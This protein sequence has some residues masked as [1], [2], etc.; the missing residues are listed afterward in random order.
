MCGD[1]EELTGTG[2]DF[3]PLSDPSFS[4]IAELIG[5]PFFILLPD[6][7]SCISISVSSSS[8]PFLLLCSGSRP[9]LL[10]LNLGF[11]AALSVR[12][13]RV[14]LQAAMSRWLGLC[15]NTKQIDC[16]SPT[17]CK[18]INSSLVPQEHRFS[19]L[20]LTPRPHPVFAGSCIN[21]SAT[22]TAKHWQPHL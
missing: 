5:P 13:R 4:L 21:P 12:D 14:N 19:G 11:Q 9:H 7:S 16:L 6:H 20:L 22:L 10:P 2:L 15:C 1:C 8:S 17:V 18:A 3:V